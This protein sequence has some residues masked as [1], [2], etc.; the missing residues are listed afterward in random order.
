LRRTYYEIRA[1]MANLKTS[2]WFETL[3]SKLIGGEIIFLAIGICAMTI[4]VLVDQFIIRIICLVIVIGSALMIFSSLRAKQLKIRAR[5]NEPA[6]H[7]HSQIGKDMMKKLIFDDFQPSSNGG[8]KVEETKEEEETVASPELPS[9]TPPSNI[10]PRD[11]QYYMPIKQDE[12]PVQ[13]EFQLSDF[14]DVDSAIFKEDAEP[15]TEFDF[16]LNKVLVVIK[17][18]LFAHTVALFWAN[19][20]KR[21]MIMESHVTDSASFF[22]SR[23]FGIGHDLISNVAMSGKPEFISEV[24]PLSESELFR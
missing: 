17:E 7:I 11:S 9:T 3:L 15:R 5:S 23:R 16:L 13:R 20:E 2:D 1:L 12:R 6:Q 24:N 14:F 10:Q 19:R 18:V 8:I 4:G 22:S 21:Q